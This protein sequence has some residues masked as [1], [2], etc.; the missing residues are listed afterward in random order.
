[1]LQ[2][3]RHPWQSW[4]DRYLKY[5]SKHPPPSANAPR[6]PPT[7]PLDTVP[8]IEAPVA[9]TNN[10]IN[11]ETN[12]RVDA[13]TN[14]GEPEAE[15]N[16]ERA[17]ARTRRA[18]TSPARSSTAHNDGPL[19][20]V[21]SQNDDTGDRLLAS[22]SQQYPT[23]PVSASQMTQKTA[24][25][26][27]FQSNL[28]STKDFNHGQSNQQQPASN[29][30]VQHGIESI[31]EQAEQSLHVQHD[32][33]EQAEEQ[34]EPDLHMQPI[35]DEE[36]EE[37]PEPMSRTLRPKDSS[38]AAPGPSIVTPQHNHSEPPTSTNTSRGI[39]NRRL[40][41]RLS[42]A[43][44][45]FRRDDFTE[46]EHD[47]LV[48]ESLHILDIR[49]SMWD[50]S[51][52]NF[53]TRYVTRTAEEWA[54]YFIDVVQGQMEEIEDMKERR[55]LRMEARRRL[56]QDKRQWLQT[57]LWPGEDSDQDN[58]AV[59][60]TI[61][62]GAIGD[63]MQESAPS[64]TPS[65]KRKHGANVFPVNMGTGG[66]FESWAE[67]TQDR[68]RGASDPINCTCTERSSCYIAP[69]FRRR[70]CCR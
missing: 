5:V 23:Q 19:L 13:E 37:Q 2:N 61:P 62:T 38:P 68:I 50:V 14:D 20:E 41:S 54:G 26:P 29:L 3:K 57:G 48:L 17:A 58:N 28:E 60:D 42:N 66:Q 7:P 12:N 52:R 69:F 31:D 33:V 56:T 1:M 59:A 8:A 36:T 49:L 16:E 39:I 32:V 34:S 25:L 4:R 43:N 64:D 65:R 45:R 18:V 35:L 22:A 70:R 24:L 67:T 10:Q 9:E 21:L 63:E 40:S 15:Q 55:R 46:P 44:A 6:A 27:A 30:D 51:W 11:T 47:I 53:A